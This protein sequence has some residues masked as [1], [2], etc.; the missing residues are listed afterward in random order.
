MTQRQWLRDV[1]H[2][3]FCGLSRS[4]IRGKHG[5]SI[6]RRAASYAKDL[7]EQAPACHRLLAA[8]EH[9][10]QRLAAGG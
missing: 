2:I 9:R 6:T 10:H 7:F 4:S 1:G 5:R 8:R 3:R